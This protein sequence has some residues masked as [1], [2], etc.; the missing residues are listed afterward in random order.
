MFDGLL[1]KERK[2][3]QAGDSRTLN[4]KFRVAS[5]EELVKQIDNSEDLPDGYIAGWASTTDIDHVGDKVLLGAFDDSIAEKGLNG[6]K[7]IKLLIQHDSSKPAGIIHKL[8][9]RSKGLWIEAQLNL[10]ISYVRDTYE[11]A[12][13]NGGLS[14]SIGYR[15]VEG[16]FRFVEKENFEDSYWELSK[17]DL[18]EVSVVTFPCNEEAT[19]T[20]I[21]GITDEEA[22]DTVAELEKALVASGLAKSRNDAQRITRVVKRNS[23]LFMAPSDPEPPLSASDTKAMDEISASLSKLKSVFN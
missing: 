7:G 4:V 2:F 5:Q 18:H 9:Q 11:A 16:G 21:K 8:E 14:F 12:K 23:V 17:L 10:E 6:P 1:T 15:L 3:L 20:F 13:M 22:F 19:M